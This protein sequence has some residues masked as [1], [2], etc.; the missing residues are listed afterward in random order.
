MATYDFEYYY[1]V[2]APAGNVNTVNAES[3]SITI[4][5]GDTLEP[6]EVITVTFTDGSTTSVTYQGISDAGE[7]YFTSIPGNQYYFAS[8]TVYSTQPPGSA[9]EMNVEDFF[10]FLSGTMIAT[11]TGD[12][13]VEDL[14][15]GDLVL[16]ATGVAVPVKWIGM[17]TV[18][19]RFGMPERRRPVLVSAGALG[20][21]LPARDL[22][23][24]ADHALL[25]DGVLVQAGALVNQTTI[26][27]MTTAE[28]GARFTVYH[29]E[30]ENHE[31]VL[32]E[33]V[34]AETFVDNV[35]RRRFDN[36]A[37]FEA[38]YGTERQGT[39]EMDLPRVKSARQLP[40]EIRARITAGAEASAAA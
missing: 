5:D 26:R 29:V 27:H 3:A 30:L 31:L 33:G 9:P 15:I 11:P 8:N 13:A 6:G 1:G 25:L 12:V 40:I 2:S 28:L 32:A 4:D 38:L 36:Y 21:D 24:T 19:S 37:E 20:A 14:A 23:L 34:A 7:P 10:C 22:K 16:T 18:V 35:S 39:G 17:Q